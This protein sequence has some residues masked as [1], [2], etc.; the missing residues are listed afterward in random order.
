MSIVAFI[1]TEVGPEN[2]KVL[3]I[4]AV[5]SDGRAYHGCS[6]SDFSAFLDG[7]DYICGHNILR[8]DLRYLDRLEDLS[9]RFTGRA[10]DTLYLS[11]L[12]FPKKP[13]HAL[14]KDDKLQTDDL[15][16]PLNDSRKAMNLF[17]DEVSAFLGMD[18][19]LQEIYYRLLGDRKEFV[20]FFS[21]VRYPGL[22]RTSSLGLVSRLFQSDMPARE[23]SRLVHTRLD[24]KICS[25]ADIS[26]MASSNPV[27]LAYAIALIN[28]MDD[29]LAERSITPPWVLRNYPE[30][31]RIMFRLR[32]APCMQGCPYCDR[33]MD[34]HVGLKRWFGFGSFRSY[35]GDPLQEK[36][37]RAAVE[38]KSLLAVFPTGGGKS[39]TFQL[40][41]LMAAENMSALTVVI[42]PLQ[43]LMKDQVDNLEAKGITE[44]VTING[45]L[46]PIER[47]KSFERVEN[48]SASILYISPESLRSPSVERMILKRKI[49]RFV[50][51]EAH[52][53]SS[54][55]QDFRVDYLY[56]AEFI[57]SVQKKKNLQ[58][59]IPVSCFTATAKPK[60]IEDIRNYFKTML[61]L[62]LQLF[63][64]AV[65]RPNLHYTV[66]PEA[67]DEEK[68]AALRRLLEEKDCPT[69]VYVSRTRKAKDIA[70]R[71]NRDGF[72]A[73]AFHGRMTPDEKI[74][75]Q[76]AFM[77]GE[78][79]IIVATSAFGMGVDKSDVG[80]V[81]HFEV[82][83]SLENYVQ[84]AGRAGRNADM[85][86]DCYIL[87]NDEDLSRHFILLNQ[88]K[89]TIK[90][91]QQIWK[92][93]KDLSRF[94]SRISNSALEIARQAGWDDSVSDIETR[95]RTAI[96]WLEQAGY[97]KRG[98]N[99]PRIYAT[100]ILARN[101]QEV[102]DRI[103]I[104]DRFRGE[105]KTNAIRIIR[106]LIA[107]RSRKASMSDEAESRVDYISDRLGIK[108]EEVVHII[109]VFR[110]EK[111]LAD[112]KDI[113]AYFSKD[114]SRTRPM[115]ILRQFIP[116][117]NFL[118]GF[119][120]ENGSRLDVRKLNAGAETEGVK[121]FNSRNMRTILNL[122]SIEG[123]VK[124]DGIPNNKNVVWVKA[125][126]P[127]DNI[128][129]GIARRQKLAV[130]ILEYLQGIFAGDPTAQTSGVVE[131]SLVEIR[132]AYMRSVTDSS[133]DVVSE[134][135][136]D[137]LFYLSRIG[138]LRIEGGFLVIYNAMT[139]ERLER[140]NKRKYRLED[141]KALGEFYEN[142][143][144]QIHIVGE[145]ARKMIDDYKEALQFV[146]DYFHMSYPLFLNRYFHNRQKEIS[147]NITPSKFR[148]I[149][150]ELSPSQLKIINDKSSRYIVVAAGP[151]SGKTRILVHK[152]A[153]LL[154]ME[155]V[156]HEQLLML[157]FS[158]AAAT[159]FKSRLCGLIGNAAS[160]VEIKTFHSYCFDLLGQEG[161]RE[162]SD[163]VEEKAL[164]M[165]RADEVDIS[166]ITRTVLVI[167]EAQDMNKKEYALVKALID[168]NEDMRVIAVGDDDQNIFEFRG[169]SSEYMEHLLGLPDAVKYELPENYRSCKNLVE[170]TEK[171]A[172]SLSHRLK[173]HTVIPKR[174]VVGELEIVKYSC[175]HLEMPLVR[176]IMEKRLAGTVAVLTRTNNEALTVAGLLQKNGLPACLIQSDYGFNLARLVEMRFFINEVLSQDTGAV[177][178]EET[179]MKARS[180]LKDRYSRSGKLTLCLK[181]LD[182]FASVNK[183][184]KYKS[185]FLTFVSESRLDDFADYDT[186][187]IFVST[188]HKV[189][190]K[191]F[192]NVFL[193]L[194][195]ECP[196]KDEKRRVLYVAM[197]RAK[198]NLYIHLNTSFLDKYG[199]EGLR[200]KYDDGVYNPPK[201]VLMEVSLRYVWLNDFIKKQSIVAK[202]MC[203]DLLVVRDGRV[204]DRNGIELVKFSKSFNKESQRLR[205]AGYEL[206]GAEA[207][208]IVWWFCHDAGTDI[209]VLLPRLHFS[210]MTG[211]GVREDDCTVGNRQ[212]GTDLRKNQ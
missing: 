60:V 31:E 54:W 171:F 93:V 99:M 200:R 178:D 167:D 107:E 52:C 118:S 111:I 2:G 44:A 51:D 5:R 144:Q 132:D 70:S 210:L 192:D 193:M 122:W 153:S 78:V 189:K 173:E 19:D 20:A 101:A 162:Q 42:S 137:A 138:S 55:G 87:F 160:F 128:R 74:E 123:L 34:V 88:T 1:D 166:R 71:L 102:I 186:S 188:I 174:N 45:M 15:N 176:S 109:N 80:L 104:S 134:D 150:G 113:S 3:D 39:L 187:A 85:D 175:G 29:H 205:D 158:R 147:M 92:A 165:I 211:V 201:E 75:N 203:G 119:L 172:G 185:D 9:G 208:T 183:D 58:E 69:I 198:E 97:L 30:V 148:K 82:S 57:G 129:A 11:P 139:I 47:A 106:S 197:T 194:D 23:I 131:F 117:E 40:P 108:R 65:S 112:T 103:N 7:A 84:E 14:L 98:Q 18:E 191:E 96:A 37:V 59:S 73:K 33:F 22:R 164:E 13:Y 12:L 207:D 120:C 28:V 76:N 180:A 67:N 46:D 63:T 8:H 79:R 159:E 140:D 49:A 206:S 110:E 143:I 152:L 89:M 136:E 155:E 64:T 83:D 4:G 156:K 149:F 182:T 124:K 195:N 170:F 116:I 114:E 168:R 141:Y 126:A 66:L 86:A 130:F 181:L 36:A 17:N 169:S 145:Y 50:I 209:Q 6:M 142:K 35:N 133:P 77:S 212:D 202:Y 41:A 62:D 115:Q 161:S 48:G 196:D 177:I 90:E 16:N 27:A 184:Q 81:V 91:I 94:R 53:F 95:V 204:F 121:N 56:I 157:T 154:M 199:A 25:H 24:G 125:M 179:W 127:A 135:V 146:D 32:S 21:F 43:S 61:G 105:Q 10:I 72:G 100:G 68:Y 163:T 151:G 190:G 38:N 26:G